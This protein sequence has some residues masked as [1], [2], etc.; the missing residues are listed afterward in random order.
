[1]KTVISN[2]ITTFLNVIYFTLLQAKIVLEDY[3]PME[4][5]SLIAGFRSDYFKKGR[6]LCASRPF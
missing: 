1:M 6:L 4:T 5:Q 3:Q 2:T